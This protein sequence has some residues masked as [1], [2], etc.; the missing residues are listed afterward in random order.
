MAT[1]SPARGSARA[2]SPKADPPA[3]PAARGAAD[4]KR[5][6]QRYQ[7]LQKAAK[8]RLERGRGKAEEGAVQPAGGRYPEPPQK[9][10]QLVKPGIEAEMDPRPAYSGERYRPAGKLEGKV[11]LIAG[12][13]SGIGRSV[14]V[15]FAREGA[16]VAVVYLSE[17]VDAEETR[18]AVEDAGRQCLLIPGDVGNSAFCQ[19][20]VA[21]V[22]KE[23]GQLDILVNNAAFQQHLPSLEDLTDEQLEQT[24]RT[25]IFGSMYMARA[26]LAHLPEGGVILNTGSITGI[27]GS[28]ELLDYSATKGAIHAFTKSLAQNLV[29]RRIRVNCVAPGPVWTPLNPADQVAEKVAQFGRDV[30]MK[31]PAQPEELAPAYVFLAS[32][33]D[34]S[35]ITGE[36]L[37]VLGGET[38][39]A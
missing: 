10:Q 24:F 2:K 15:L 37:P 20:A 33:G 6:A 4:G 27:Q 25:N 22:V 13:D 12:G 17:D 3:K 26:A 14:A 21:R 36:V 29:E 19:D 31:R 35:Y 28:K 11:A 34:A 39:G 7:A 23:F 16:D 5:T 38:I 8:P 30:P 1:K 9:A 18:R 32:D